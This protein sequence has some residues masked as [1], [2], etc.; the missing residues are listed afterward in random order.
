MLRTTLVILCIA[1]TSCA[2]GPDESSTGSYEDTLDAGVPDADVDPT[3]PTDPPRRP[4]L[5][6]DQLA[7]LRLLEGARSQQALAEVYTRFAVRPARLEFQVHDVRTSSLGDALVH[8]QQVYAGIPV[9]ARDLLVVVMLDGQIRVFGQ[10]DDFENIQLPPQVSHSNRAE[11]WAHQHGVTLGANK[12]VLVPVLE[13]RQRP[14]TSGTNATDWE[15]V[16][17]SFDV[18]MVFPVQGADDYRGP[19]EIFVSDRGGKIVERGGPMY[20]LAP[21]TLRGEHAPT[22]T[23]IATV[24]FDNTGKYALQDEFANAVRVYNGAYYTDAP[25]NIWGDGFAYSG[26]GVMT[27]NGETAAADALI[28]M[29]ANDRMYRHVFGVG[30]PHPV[31]ASV[32]LN[33]SNSQSFAN[34]NT[35][36]IDLGYKDPNALFK[37]GLTDVEVVGHEMGHLML[38]SR[39]G[40]N[41]YGSL[42]EQGGLVEGNADIFGK[43]AGFYFPDAMQPACS[44]TTCTW[45][46]TLSIT[47]SWVLADYANANVRRDFIYPTI[48]TWSPALGGVEAHQAGGP[49]RLAYYYLTVGIL[50]AGDTAVPGYGSPQ[51]SSLLVPSGLTGLGLPLA[52]TIWWHT[53]NDGFYNQST[54]DYAGFRTA[55]LMSTEILYGKQNTTAYKA[56]QDAFA[57]IS[58][59]PPADRI[60]PAIAIDVKQTSRTVA[61]I[62]VDITDDSGIKSGVVTIAHAFKNGYPEVHACTGHCVFQIDALWYG[63]STHHKVRV[64]ATDNA[65]NYASKV[66]PFTID[67]SPPTITLASLIAAGADDPYQVWDVQITDET[68]LDS[69]NIK[70]DGTTVETRSWPILPVPSYT[71]KSFTVDKRNEPDGYTVVDFTARDVIGNEAT[72]TVWLVKDTTGPERCQL[73]VGSTNNYYNEAEV[74][75]NVVGMDQLSG[76]KYLTVYEEGVGMIVKKISTAG[77][78]VVDGIFTFDTYSPGKHTFYGTCEDQKGNVSYTQHVSYW[79]AKPCGTENVSGGNMMDTRTFELGKKSGTVKLAYQTYGIEDHITVKYEGRIIKDLGCIA[80]P[81]PKPNEPPPLPYATEFSYSGS[82]TQITITVEPNCNP[83][84]TSPT[85]EWNYSVFCP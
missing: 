15:T 39:A 12:R 67:V 41:S 78:A 72:K 38:V 68:A 55:M 60:P 59:G 27:A 35:W 23:N 45:A 75:Q 47:R 5:S 10:P 52:S 73:I 54:L 18:G 69:A 58:V 43:H 34:G 44:G 81:D 61:E 30:L 83:F 20:S 22:I 80:T 62:T 57:A 53:I 29:W 40:I 77:P 19:T 79:V 24:K 74:A 8:I 48:D 4:D 9:E 2:S 37:I 26:G 21:A 51:R 25:D 42:G 6:E 82:S 66:Q 16:V 13:R 1:C 76:L 84:N 70:V 28:S 36:T 56:V 17:A 46:S 7:A 32:H 11:G 50:A 71:F 3:P 49:L 33:A 63:T 14:G 85:T 64:D 31:I 65:D